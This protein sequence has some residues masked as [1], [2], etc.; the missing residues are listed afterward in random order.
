MKKES[1]G[2]KSWKVKNI[3][4]FLVTTAK[5]FF[6]RGREWSDACCRCM[7]FAVRVIVDTFAGRV[8]IYPYILVFKDDAMIL[9][10]VRRSVSSASSSSSSSSSLRRVH[11]FCLDLISAWCERNDYNIAA[12][13]ITNDSHATIDILY[14]HMTNGLINLS[15]Q[16]TYYIRIDVCSPWATQRHASMKVWKRRWV[17]TSDA[18][19]YYYYCC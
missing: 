15:W 8:S 10:F 14:T 6:T 13:T 2:D 3:S 18:Q 16:S 19:C 17:A 9:Y 5:N 11:M 1:G 7:C 4:G 12:G